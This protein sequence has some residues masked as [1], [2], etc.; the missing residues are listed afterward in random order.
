[1]LNRSDRAPS[2]PPEAP[3]WPVPSARRISA[4][5]PGSGVGMQNNSGCQHC[6]R[7]WS[8]TIPS[9]R[10]SEY[11]ADF[12]ASYLICRFPAGPGEPKPPWQRRTNVWRKA[13]SPA[14][15]ACFRQHVAFE[16][17]AFLRID[18]EAMMK[19]LK[20]KRIFGVAL[21]TTA[22]IAIA[23]VPFTPASAITSF[24]NRC[25]K[26][27]ERV[28]CGRFESLGDRSGADEDEDHECG[29]AGASSGS[30]GARMSTEQSS[31][32]PAGAGGP[33]QG[34]GGAASA[35][36]SG[37]VS[38]GQASAGDLGRGAAAGH[39]FA[40]GAGG[41]A[42]ANPDP[43]PETSP[44]IWHGGSGTVDLAFPTVPVPGPIAGAGLPGLILASGGLLGWWRRRQKI[45]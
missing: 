9:G 12:P 7:L 44:L 1:M 30:S 26:H 17:C 20:N 21:V 29:C 45:V 5:A 28:S 18:R 40:S 4:P 16:F 31:G 8:A 23:T 15:R 39:F 27:W 11:S 35:G 22:W 14:P 25:D 6:R 38:G 24:V 19:R 36:G 41:A 3:H 33:G 13:T 42:F 43:A 34:P 32:S 37:Q 10:Q 2:T